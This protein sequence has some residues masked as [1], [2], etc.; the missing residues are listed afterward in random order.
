[1]S[2]F[3]K[4]KQVTYHL[5]LSYRCFRILPSVLFFQAKFYAPTLIL[6]RDMLGKTS[7][8]S[9]DFS[10]MTD[11]FYS[12]TKTNFTPVTCFLLPK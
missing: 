8:Y 9:I 3:G 12:F 6:L 1:M 4:R 5:N 11:T 2:Y 10:G 7:L